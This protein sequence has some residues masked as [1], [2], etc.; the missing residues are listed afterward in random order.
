[1]N[2]RN[3]LYKTL[4]TTA[5]LGTTAG[6]LITPRRVYAAWPKVAFDKKDLSDAIKSIY[7]ESNL[8]E[9]TKVELKAPDI[10]ENG[11]I[12][13]IN[14]KTKLKNVESIMIFVEHNPQPL[15]SGY[16]LTSLSEPKIGTRIKMGKTSKIVA[17][18]KSDGKVYSASKEVKV[19]IGGCGG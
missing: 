5:V 11:A 12:V 1:M 18:I 17:T 8:V 14:V 19:T 15:S 2:R 9:S 7:G 6:I 4:L 10:A 13:P 16:M 3:F